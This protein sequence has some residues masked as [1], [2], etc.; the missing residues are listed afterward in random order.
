MNKNTEQHKCLRFT[1]GSDPTEDLPCETCHLGPCVYTVPPPRGP[2]KRK[3]KQHKP[4]AKRKQFPNARDIQKYMGQHNDT[5]YSPLYEKRLITRF[6]D[7]STS[8][9]LTASGPV[10]SCIYHSE[11]LVELNRLPNARGMQILHD[12]IYMDYAAANGE[13]DH[14]WWIRSAEVEF[15]RE[16]I[17]EILYFNQSMIE[18]RL[19]EKLSPSNYVDQ[20]LLFRDLRNEIS[21]TEAYA[22]SAMR[23]A[24]KTGF[25]TLN[26]LLELEDCKTLVPNILKTLGRLKNTVSE[27]L[28]VMGDLSPKYR[29]RRLPDLNK[30]TLKQILDIMA[31]AKLT[32]DFGIEPLIR[33]IDSVCQSMKRF[34]S[35]FK[36]FK[37]GAKALNQTRHFKASIE[38]TS[39]YLESFTQTVSFSFMGKTISYECRLTGLDPQANGTPDG[40]LAYNATMDYTY[41]CKTLMDMDPKVAALYTQL[42]IKPDASIL[43]N[44]IPF[45]FVFDW[46]VDISGF[47]SKYAS[48]ELITSEVTIHSWLMGLRARRVWTCT[49]VGVTWSIPGETGTYL[50]PTITLRGQSYARILAEPDIEKLISLNQK[51]PDGLTLNRGLLSAAL[52]KKLVFR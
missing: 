9:I 21:I 7:G 42:G 17:Y 32:K 37:E 28:K 40:H 11:Q 35:N 13:G 19:V 2:A 30:A 5:L 50:L 29:R 3:P 16:S 8:N 26:F 22:F 12:K 25:S 1:A 34:E 36:R 20:D 10:G 18:A 48:L 43:W 24:F 51:T 41:A 23:P 47:L 15:P 4:N 45:S 33:D 27:T 31:E 14:Y 52:L 39:E 49:P 6:P 46:F 38:A 44:A